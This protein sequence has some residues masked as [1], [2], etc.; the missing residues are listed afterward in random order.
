MEIINTTQDKTHKQI[1]ELYYKKESIDTIEKKIWNR[2]LQDNNK[3]T[4]KMLLEIQIKPPK[5]CNR[6]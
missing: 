3:A 2:W 4:Y 1:V 6:R 5:G